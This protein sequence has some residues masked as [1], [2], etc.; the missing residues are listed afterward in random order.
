MIDAIL[1]EI[2]Q[3][4]PNGVLFSDHPAAK[5]RAAWKIVQQHQTGKT[6][7]QCKAIIKRWVV[8]RVLV[9]AEFTNP[10]NRH[11]ERGLKHGTS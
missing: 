2:D 6:E 1:R 10:D 4:L 11:Q 7:A 5:E 3:G 8:N 9:R